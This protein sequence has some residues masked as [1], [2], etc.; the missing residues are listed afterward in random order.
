MLS[1]RTL[2]IVSLVICLQGRRFI[3]LVPLARHLG[4]ILVPIRDLTEGVECD[5]RMGHQII[6]M[7]KWTLLV[8]K[9]L[10]RIRE[11]I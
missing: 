6:S 11:E 7:F 4:L 8:N 10:R 3:S 1:W 5:I 9:H 2:L